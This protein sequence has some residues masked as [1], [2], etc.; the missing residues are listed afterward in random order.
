MR[1]LCF[2]IQGKM[3][4]F[5]R[6]YSNSS[7]LTYSIPPRT[8]VAGI[9]AGLLGLERDS[10]YEIFS[11]DQ[12]RIAVASCSP[13]KKVM[14][15]MNLLKVESVNDLN[16]F[17]EHHSQTATEF[18]LPQNIRTGMIDY[19]VWFY[20]VDQNI[21]GKL[22]NILSNSSVINGYVSA[23]ISLALGTAGN[24]GW[25]TYEGVLEGEEIQE[26]VNVPIFSSIPA[27]GIKE[28][29]V[30]KTNMVEYRLVKEDMPFEFDRGRRL[31]NR[32]KGSMIINLNSA[33][34]FAK[35]SHHIR[36]A[37]HESIMWMQ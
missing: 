21:M 27:S 26:E 12:C 6:Y 2:R 3:A 7:S 36:L 31:T 28:I 16:G 35:V 22:E 29:V 13:I 9:V 15:K 17:Q 32:G 37:N 20:H 33:P 30:E 10:Y 25:L 24:L 18:V 1:L 8:T 5:R 11:L 34:I 4:H 14:Q 23:G 19:R